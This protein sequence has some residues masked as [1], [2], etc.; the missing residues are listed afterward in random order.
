MLHPEYHFDNNRLTAGASYIRRQRDLALHNLKQHKPRP[1]WQ[2]FGRL[3][4]AAQDFYAHTNYVRL[5]IALH[6]GPPELTAPPDLIDPLTP[7]LL[8]S[9]DLYSGRLDWFWETISR[10]PGLQAYAQRRA[11]DGSHYCMNLDSPEQGPLFAYAYHAALKR[12]Q[13]EHTQIRVDLAP[14]LHA[15]FDGSG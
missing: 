9:K 6:T 10:V 3:L 2:A 5:W 4:H 12:T 14:T 15:V 8:D 11:P 7:R 1:A 13:V